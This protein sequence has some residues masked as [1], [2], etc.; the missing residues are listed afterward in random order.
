MIPI[1]ASGMYLSFS[2]EAYSI[3]GFTI[4][5]ARNSSRGKEWEHIFQRFGNH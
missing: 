3:S 4:M 1:K 5:L 2:S